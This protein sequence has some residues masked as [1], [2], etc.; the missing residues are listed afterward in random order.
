MELSRHFCKN[1]QKRVGGKPSAQQIHQILC[2]SVR[3]QK[4]QDVIQTNGVFFRILAIYWHP[5]RRLFIKV[6]AKKK[7]AITVLTEGCV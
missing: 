1:W 4:G 7:V 2:E 6:D 3:V 5:H